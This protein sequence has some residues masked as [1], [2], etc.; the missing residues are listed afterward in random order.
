ME[1]L[2][3]APVWYGILL[4]AS[5]A[6]LLNAAVFT[7][8]IYG[9]LGLDSPLLTRVCRVD[10]GD[11]RKVVSSPRARLFGVPN[12]VLGLAWYLAVGAASAA[13]L[14]TGALP[15][16]PVLIAASAL[17]IL[18]GVYLV[19][20]LRVQLQVHCAFCYLGHA[21]NAVIFAALLA[22]R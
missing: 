9:W 18:L 2:V 8:I 21:A 13:A 14:A 5:I 16:R 6:G 15:F 20:S 22:A 17:T 10:S 19:W 7:A 4:A 12:S 11:C 3:S 1:T